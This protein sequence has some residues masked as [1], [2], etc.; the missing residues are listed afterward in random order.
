MNNLTQTQQDAKQAYLQQQQ[1]SMLAHYQNADTSER[2]AIIKHIDSFLSTCNQD[3]KTF[4]LQFRR[5]LEKL[6]ESAILFPLGNVY[7]TVGAQDA[8]KESNELPNEFLAQHQMG[9]WGIVCQDDW[10]END[11]S[12]KNGF[13]IL[14]A[15]NTKQGEKIWII[16][17]SDRSAT[18]VL[19]PS[20]Y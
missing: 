3:Q 6:S 13:R 5:K 1:D 9:E 14:S 20:E 19:L 2:N 17:E 15:Y 16:T 7:L 10:K 11:F 18:T 4:W 8:L 12:V